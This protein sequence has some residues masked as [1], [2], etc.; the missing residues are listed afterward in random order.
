MNLYV[1]LIVRLIAA[2]ILRFDMS[3]EQVEDFVG[4][5]RQLISDWLK[6]QAC[7]TA[8]NPRHDAAVELMHLG[9][10]GGPLP[11]LL[12][13]DALLDP[14]RDHFCDVA[15]ADRDAL[16]NQAQR[17][18][19]GLDLG[20]QRF[21]FFRADDE[22]RQV[23]PEGEL[24]LPAP[25][26]A[27]VALAVG[28]VAPDDQAGVDQRRQ[29]APERRH[30]HAVRPQAELMVRREDHE[31]FAGQDGFRVEGQQRVQDGQ[32]AL[33]DAQRVLGRAYRTENI[34]FMDR[35]L[36]RPRFCARLARHMGK[37]QRSPPK[38]RR[39]G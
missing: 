6:R 24:D 34:P 9:P 25:A 21:E 33:G 17:P 10:V 4:E 30:R 38:G 19:F 29:M 39:Y 7:R 37:R 26:L 18:G 32:R 5:Q 23:E 16:T 35:L 3:F 1:A 2:H 14:R 15:A 13:R 27:G 8:R 31:T 36:G 11:S 22:R 12:R 28:A 20:R